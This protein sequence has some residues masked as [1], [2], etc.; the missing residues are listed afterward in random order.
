[1]YFH[2][3]RSTQRHMHKRSFTSFTSILLCLLSLSSC[4]LFGGTSTS[5]SYS[6]YEDDEYEGDEDYGY[7]YKRDYTY[8]K[9]YG[10]RG[11]DLPGTDHYTT[12][13]RSFDEFCDTDDHSHS[14][15]DEEGLKQDIEKVRKML[16]QLRERKVLLTSFMLSQR[17]RDWTCSHCYSHNSHWRTSCSACYQSSRSYTSTQVDE[18]Y[19]ALNECFEHI[20]VRLRE[21]GR[22]I[23]LSNTNPQ[24]WV[25]RTCTRLYAH[26]ETRCNVCSH[27]PQP[28]SYDRRDEETAFRRYLDNTLQHWDRLRTRANDWYTRIQQFWQSLA[29]SERL[30]AR[31]QAQ[32]SG[33][34]L[35]Q[36]LQAQLDQTGAY[37]ASSSGASASAH[38]PV[39]IPEAWKCTAIP[40]AVRK[41]G[42][43][44]CCE[45]KAFQASKGCRCPQ[46]KQFFC[47][48]CFQ[49]IVKKSRTPHRYSYNPDADSEGSP[50]SFHCSTQAACPF[51]C[52]KSFGV[53]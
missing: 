44:I 30:L 3:I 50:Y 35:G 45:E 19:K 29:E 46:C 23:T 42:C 2:A 36:F 53:R 25:C 4:N 27:E 22:R 28:T 32:A 34:T 18:E 5:S 49:N 11:Y 15:E 47:Q 48:E 13:R 24:R 40:D 37:G 21:G 52:K 7:G 33:I 10:Y 6:I 16:V 43:L 41:E 12:R 39:R 1:M 9:P 38:P 17:N 8:R 20:L 14:A 31:S 51:G 26:S